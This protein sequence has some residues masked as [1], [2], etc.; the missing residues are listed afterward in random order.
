M[1]VMQLINDKGSAVANHFVITTDKGS[2]L[3]SYDSIVAFKPNDTFADS[4]LGGDWDYSQTTLKYVKQFLGWSSYTKAE[5][6]KLI[7]RGI[8]KL[9]AELGVR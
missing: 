7:E 2:Y 5:L 8:V 4:V 3:Q 9:D 6:K 1:K